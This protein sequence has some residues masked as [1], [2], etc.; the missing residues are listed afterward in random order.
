M[1][2]SPTVLATVRTPARRDH[3]AIS[4]PPPSGATIS[5][6][7]PLPSAGKAAASVGSMPS[8]SE[9]HR[10]R[11]VL[12]AEKPFSQPERRRRAPAG[13]G[14]DRGI[15]RLEERQEHGRIVGQRHDEM[16]RAGI[17]DEPDP[18]TGP[19]GPSP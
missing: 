10:A 7:R 1:S 4:L 13:G 9:K 15:E 11:G 14:H 18:A 17:G 16:R 8:V 5:A 12:A 3:S 6:A 2:V 19:D